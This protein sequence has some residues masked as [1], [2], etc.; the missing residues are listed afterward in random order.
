MVAAQLELARLN[1]PPYI[2]PVSKDGVAKPDLSKGNKQFVLLHRDTKIVFPLMPKG[3]SLAWTLL[4]SQDEAGGHQFSFSPQLNWPGNKIFFDSCIA[5]IVT[6]DAQ[7]L[8]R[9]LGGAVCTMS[10]KTVTK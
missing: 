10:A 2:V 6:T 1:G 5:D 4:I 9:S 8:D 3:K 7:T